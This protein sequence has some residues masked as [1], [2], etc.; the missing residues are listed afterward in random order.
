MILPYRGD[1]YRVRDNKL[2][3]DLGQVLFQP[4][5]LKDDDSLIKCM[6]YSNV[7]IN[8]I[9]R[10]WPTKNFSLHDVNV[11]GARRIA[12]LAKKCGVERFIHMSHLNASPNPKVRADA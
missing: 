7:V 5:H 4:F 1:F 2:S 3:G 8:L 12:A 11:D 6:K 10:E 9:G